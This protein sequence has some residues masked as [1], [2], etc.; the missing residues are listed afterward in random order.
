VKVTA[1][2]TATV[3]ATLRIGATSQKVE[4]TAAAPLVEDTP[5]NFTTPLQPVYIQDMPL[6]GRDIQ[7]LVQLIPG[8]TQSAGPS[9]AIFGFNSQF[10]GFPDPLHIVGSNISANGGQGGANVWFLDGTPNTSSFAGNVVVNPSPD[11][12]SEFKVVDNGLAA[13][14]GRTSGAVVNVVL[15]S[16]TNSLYGDIYELNQNSYF[17]ATNPFARRDT[18]GRPFLQPRVNMNNCHRGKPL[19]LPVRLEKV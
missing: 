5:S 4:V 13:E 18:Q 1:G 10:G 9:G 7:A 8:V 3:N 17:S 19:V 11:A 2:V 12:V 16:G 14:W 6:P 15:K